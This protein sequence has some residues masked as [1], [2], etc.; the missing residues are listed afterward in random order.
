MTRGSQP[1]L[2]TEDLWNEFRAKVSAL[3]GLPTW[4]LGVCSRSYSDIRDLPANP[5]MEEVAKPNLISSEKSLYLRI[6]EQNILPV[7]QNKLGQPVSKAAQSQLSRYEALRKIQGDEFIILKLIRNDRDFSCYFD[8]ATRGLVHFEQFSGQFVPLS[9]WKDLL[10][11]W[12]K[13]ILVITLLGILSFG[14][15]PTTQA[16]TWLFI[17]SVGVFATVV[18]VFGSESL[19]EAA[20]PALIIA[21]LGGLV[22][23]ALSRAMAR[24]QA[25]EHRDQR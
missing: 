6:A 17:A 16:A 10:F 2:L 20:I 9:R 3:D 5:T 22:L 19:V 21:L 4:V 18:L 11:A 8:G 1:I 25:I 23:G 15:A 13:I 14:T 12:R 7:A 24:K